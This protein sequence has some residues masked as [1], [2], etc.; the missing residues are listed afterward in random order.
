MHTALML[1]PLVQEPT[2][3]LQQLVLERSCSTLQY[4]QSNGSPERAAMPRCR[5]T[6]GCSCEPKPAVDALHSLKQSTIYLVRLLVSQAQ[7]CEISVTLLH[8]TS[9]SSGQHKFKVGETSAFPLCFWQPHAH[10]HCPVAND[11]LKLS[12]RPW[13][14]TDTS[15]PAWASTAGAYHM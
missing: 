12:K 8:N 3:N 9:S 10:R 7:R 5:C 6:S 11:P 1:S 4:Q 15:A 14:T 13:C 2:S